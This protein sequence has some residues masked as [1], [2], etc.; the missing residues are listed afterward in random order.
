MTK[1][2]IPRIQS[3][4]PAVGQ[5]WRDLHYRNRTLT[6]TGFEPRRYKP[7]VMM[8]VCFAFNSETK[9]LTVTRIRADRFNWRWFAPRRAH[10]DFM[11]RVGFQYLEPSVINVLVG[12]GGGSGRP[13]MPTPD[14]YGGTPLP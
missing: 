8:A 5:V 9:R 1:A 14:E 12:G 10:P 3:P 11:V 6:I 4:L 2:F 7:H 13:Q